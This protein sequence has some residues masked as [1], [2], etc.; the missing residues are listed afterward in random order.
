MTLE[1]LRVFC[2]VAAER[3]FSRAARKLRRT[4]PAV[5]QAIRRLEQ[6]AGERLIDRSS[7]DGTL[8]DAG[9][10]LLEYGGRLLRLTEEA[11][12]AVT[13]LRDVRKGRVLLGANE[14]GVYAVL[15][16]VA[17][18]QRHYPDIVVEVRRVPSRQMAQEVLLRSLDFGVLTFNPPE[19]ELASV[20]IG[21]DELVLLVPP[22][23]ALAKERQIT[24]E[25]MGQQTVIA[26]ND[27]SPA[28]DHVLRMS[29][30]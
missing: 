3:S 12:S 28:R 1:D 5:S 14:G 26:H 8:T 23:H 6:S 13:A 27:P 21:I 4:Q 18:F 17:A 10:L 19:R 15:A 30:R 29:R 11:A 24:M 7:R 20:V 22:G 9:Q 16:L 25:I 2:T